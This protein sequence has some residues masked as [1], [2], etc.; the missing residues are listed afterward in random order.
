MDPLKQLVV[1]F[2][3]LPGIGERTALRL[4]F[5]LLKDRALMFA[6]AKNLEEVAH[7]I[8]DCSV[9]CNVTAREQK[10]E[11]CSQGNRDATTICV[12]STV[13]DLMAIESTAEY[14]GSY[15]VLHGNLSPLDGIGPD[16]IRFKELLARLANS[17]VPVKEIIIATPSSV[18]GEATAIFLQGQLNGN[19]IHVSRIASGVPVGGELQFADRLTLSRSI[20][21][22]R[23]CARLD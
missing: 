17:E 5:A 16:K 18:E 15:H 20:F 9:C 14:R 1:N 22:R 6:L 2:A 19:A 21:Q 13:Q 11:I 12:V 4:S 3:K 8:R 10:C 23:R 7:K